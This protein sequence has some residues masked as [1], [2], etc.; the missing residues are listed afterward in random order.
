M[1]IKPFVN[2]NY[3]T[4]DA[5]N[6]V[7]QIK[8]KIIAHGGA[9]VLMDE[10]PIGLITA[11][12]IITNNYNLV[13]DCLSE[14]P[15]VS[16][17]DTVPQVLQMMQ[18]SGS[19]TLAVYEDDLLIG[20]IYKNDMTSHLIESIELS[21]VN[22]Q[23][24]AHDLRTPIANMMGIINIL[25]DSLEGSDDQ[26]LISSAKAA[27]VNASNL[28]NELLKPRQ[29]TEQSDQG[30]TIEI[31]SLL[32]ECIA[33]IQISVLN[34]SIEMEVLLPSEEIFSFGQAQTVRRAID[35]ILT[36][37]LKFTR[38][39]GKICI[40]ASPEDGYCLVSISDNG[41]GIP[42]KFKPF[43]F[44]RYTTAKRAGT[45]GEQTTGM[46][47]HIT[48]NICEQY[49]IELDFKSTESEGTTFYLRFALADKGKIT[50]I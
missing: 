39:Q 4:V 22:I 30:E 24:V 8:H 32:K 18:R 10:R 28:I 5:Y 40:K 2:G 38:E 41:I 36:N 27:Y 19:D 7:K 29:S 44:Q 31:V 25:E 48:K 17:R 14:K 6:A 16:P 49:G 46:G 1:N 15:K 23:D 43:L 34:K 47:L 37:A 50:Y 42:D 9:V 33:D 11:N 45:S 3:T 20:T 13:I 21:N 35:N 12:D 26:E